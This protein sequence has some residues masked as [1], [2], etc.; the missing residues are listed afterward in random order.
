VE[1]AEPQVV[2]GQVSSGVGRS[3]SNG[4]ERSRS[5]T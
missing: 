4:A 5:N 2:D 3:W 1:E